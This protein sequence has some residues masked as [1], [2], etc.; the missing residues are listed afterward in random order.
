VEVAAVD[1]NGTANVDVDVDADVDVIIFEELDV[2]DGLVPVFAG[3][4]VIDGVFFPGE[5]KDE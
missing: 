3:E 4:L 5:D 1:A 2:D